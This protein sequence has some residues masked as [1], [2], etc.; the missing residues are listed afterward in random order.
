[1]AAAVGERL[2]RGPPLA[3]IESLLSFEAKSTPRS[4]FGAMT[5][6]ILGAGGGFRFPDWIGTDS[7]ISDED[8]QSLSGDKQA[9]EIFKLLALLSPFATEIS[10]MKNSIETALGRVSEID[11]RNRYSGSFMFKNNS[12]K[13]DYYGLPDNNEMDSFC[14]RE[15]D[16]PHSGSPLLPETHA[17]DPFIIQKSRQLNRRV[18]LNVGGVRHE[19]MWN[20]LEQVPRSRLGKLVQATTHD[21]ILSLCDTYSLVDNEYFFDRHPRS[22]NSILNFYRTGKLHV[23]DEM[24]VLAFSDDLEY[25]MIDEVFL[26]SCCQNKYNTRKEHVVEEM[27]KEA[28]NIKK[29][30]EENFGDG[31][32]VKYQKCL[33]AMNI[34]DVLAILPYYVSLF[35]MGDDTEISTSLT[36][37]PSSLIEDEETGT[38]FDDVRR[39]VQVFRIMRIMRIFKLAR[40][41][42][43]LQSIAFTLKNSY[44]E[45][46]LLMLFLAMGVLIF[47]SLCYFAEKDEHKTKF[48][49]IPASFWWAI[50]TMTTVGYGDLFPTTGL[51]KLIG[52]CCA[53][54]GVLVMAL[55]IPIIVNN[56]AEFYNDQM[57]REKAVKRKE[58]L[59]QAR[60]DEEEAR[61][62]EVEGL[63]DLLQREPGPFKS[64]PLSPPDGLTI[65]NANRPRENSVFSPIRSPQ[66]HERHSLR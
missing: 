34:V 46:G 37:T 40:H 36:T 2:R 24:C 42:T 1:M 51:G 15:P 57:K 56:F 26:E 25:W 64:P 32:F 30:V 18:T 22:F 63:V 23:I 41:S 21:H 31:K 19:V 12:T 55:P 29:E 4:E 13:N 62:A 11:A 44:K 7:V 14:L 35:L 33:G 61:L 53:I 58:A 17:P 10:S 43:G 6:D 16:S 60:R 47:S 20:M 65:R 27:K 49:S 52:T 9:E 3:S 8:F 54:S 28:N 66:L 5:V 50:I 48:T 38:S 39:I 45:L 59:E